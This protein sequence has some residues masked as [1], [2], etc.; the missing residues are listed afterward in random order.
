[1]SYMRDMRWGPTTRKRLRIGRFARPALPTSKQSPGWTAANDHRWDFPQPS[2]ITYSNGMVRVIDTLIM[3]EA[4]LVG[5]DV[6]LTGM[7]CLGYAFLAVW[8]A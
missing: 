3:F 6:R 4:S 8:T 7:A 2:D 5:R 1:M